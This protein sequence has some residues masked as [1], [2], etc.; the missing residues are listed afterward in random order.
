MR[1]AV[2]FALSLTMLLTASA[3]HAAGRNDNQ[4]HS[5]AHANIGKVSR[6]TQN[7]NVLLDV[8]VSYRRDDET[9]VTRPRVLA[10]NGRDVTIKIDEK[11]GNGVF[12]LQMR[13]TAN[14]RG[15]VNLQMRTEPNGPVDSMRARLGKIS[16]MKLG[17]AGE[18]SV[19]VMPTLL[20]PGAS[21][22]A[23]GAF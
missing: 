9:I 11:G 21:I 16:Q 13:P 19:K 7:K 17:A 3:A 12:F 4:T 23:V 10:A 22:P 15:Q 8:E 14:D 1:F 2:M 6:K 18:F 20:D 5:F